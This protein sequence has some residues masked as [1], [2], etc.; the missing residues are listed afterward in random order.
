MA[1]LELFGTIKACPACAAKET[2]GD[3]VTYVAYPYP[4]REFG[5]RYGMKTLSTVLTGIITSTCWRCGYTWREL[6]LQ[7]AKE[8]NE[9]T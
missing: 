8:N 7:Y 1:E 9:A 3:G 2:W 6:T 4:L 5:R